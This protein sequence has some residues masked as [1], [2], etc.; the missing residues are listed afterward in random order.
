MPADPVGKLKRLQA[1]AEEAFDDTALA[2]REEHEQTR[3]QKFLH[4]WVLVGRSF[5]RNRC[6]VRASSLAYASL[7]ALVPMIAVVIGISSSLLQR[8]GEQTV[9]QFV[10]RLV[11]SVTPDAGPAPFTSP[12]EPPAEGEDALAAKAELVQET[13]D[14]ISRQIMAFVGNIRG[15]TLSATGVIALLVV[16]LSMLARIEDAFNDIWGVNR[17]RPWHLRVI[18][19]WF[20]I[21]LGPVLLISTVALTSGPHLDVVRDF[22]TRFGVA[23]EAAMKTALNLLPYVL[24]SIAFGLLYLFMPHTRVQWR[25][26]AVGGVVAGVLWQTNQEFSVLY[27]SRVVSNTNI[28]GSLGA[29]PVFMIGL[30]I[31]WIILLFGAQVAYAF[32]N[33]RAYLQERQ[34]ELVNQRSREFIGLRLLTRIGACYHEGRPAPSLTRLSEDLGI[35]SRLATQILTA[36]QTAGLVAETA[37]TDPGFV[38]ARP[39]ASI[40]LADVLRALRDLNGRD[41]ST[42]KDP[43]RDLLRAEFERVAAAEAT[44]AGATLQDLVTR[45]PRADT[46][47][48]SVVTANPPAGITTPA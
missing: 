16:V 13:R 32:Q 44:A 38:P 28:Y 43:A 7:L 31:C 34:V 22:L 1:Q 5:V 18:Q 37:G 36:L 41:L 8:R 15:G 21:S 3:L 26:A 23:G 11:A 48:P 35:P 47:A 39:L 6:P 46:D 29:I 45:T 30:Y 40:Q 27:V 10:A 42:R 2:R 14:Q 24:L 19:Y 12:A 25:A 20:A 9:E 4:F 17:G 33:R